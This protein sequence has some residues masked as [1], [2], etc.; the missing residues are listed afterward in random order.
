MYNMDLILSDS[1]DPR[2]LGVSDIQLR[3]F[4]KSVWQENYWAIYLWLVLIVSFPLHSR[5]AVFVFSCLRGV[6]VTR[7][8]A[9]VH[10]KAPLPSFCSE[11]QTLWRVY[12][13]SPRGLRERN[14]C[15]WGRQE[16]PAR[17]P[18]SGGDRDCLP[19]HIHQKSYLF[20]FFS[21]G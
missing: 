21:L 19:K 6:C 12:A 16:R 1:W 8:K 5:K 4:N 10:W 13:A 3:I 17:A 18:T 2:L 9:E 11:S 7:Q 14:C 20:T 15:P